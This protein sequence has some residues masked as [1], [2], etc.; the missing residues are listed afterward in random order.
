MNPNNVK[1]TSNKNNSITKLAPDYPNW[2][3]DARIAIGV[4]EIDQPTKKLAISSGIAFNLSG[5]LLD[6]IKKLKN[7]H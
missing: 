7:K 6:R 3:L 5:R 2:I 4:G 1:N